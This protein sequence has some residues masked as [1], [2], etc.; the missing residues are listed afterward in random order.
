MV[1]LVGGWCTSKQSG[2][3]ADLNNACLLNFYPSLAA[4]NCVRNKNGWVPTD[5]LISEAES[6]GYESVRGGRTQPVLGVWLSM[7]AQGWAS[8]LHA[9][10]ARVIRKIF[11][12]SWSCS[13]L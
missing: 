8:C 7:Q 11:R 6:L 2:I 4:H 12:C 13:R 10:L 9:Y 1:G 5:Q 3:L